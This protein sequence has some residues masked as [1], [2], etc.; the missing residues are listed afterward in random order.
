MYFRLIEC[1]TSHNNTRDHEKDL[2]RIL[3]QYPES[4]EASAVNYEPHILVNYLQDLANKFHTYYNAYK[5]IVPEE[6]IRNARLGL[7]SAIKIVLGN[8]LKILGVSTPE[9]M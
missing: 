9:V 2:L 4:I 8:S 7:I 1:T 3:A 6:D 5:F